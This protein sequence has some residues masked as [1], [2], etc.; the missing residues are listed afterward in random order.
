MTA[1]ISHT[2]YAHVLHSGTLSM[3]IGLDWYMLCNPETFS[4]REIRNQVKA[5]YSGQAVRT[6]CRRRPPTLKF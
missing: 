4:E 5:T 1:T 3:R 2:V 6:P